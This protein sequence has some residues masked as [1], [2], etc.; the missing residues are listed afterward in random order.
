V[1]L[2]QAPAA[3]TPAPALPAE[4]PTRG[5]RPTAPP[6]PRESNPP[7]I[8]GVIALGSMI[9]ALLLTGLMLLVW[10]RWRSGG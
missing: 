10:L 8:L 4:L 7:A 9:T 3:A 2:A 5:T 1:V 6:A